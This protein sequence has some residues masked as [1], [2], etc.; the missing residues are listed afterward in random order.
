MYLADVKTLNQTHHVNR[1]KARFARLLRLTPQFQLLGPDCV[2]RADAEICIRNKFLEAY[3]AE[4]QAFLPQLLSMKC[5]GRLSGVA[6]ICQAGRQQLFLERYLS[7]PVEQ[8]LQEKLGTATHRNSIVEIG[9]LVATNNGASLAIFIVLATL[10]YQAGFSHMVFTATEKLRNKFEK[11]GFETA[12][13]ADADP[14]CLVG[15]DADCW[16]SYYANKPQ[17]VAGDLLMACK[18]IAGR[19]LFSCIELAFSAQI[20]SL[21]EQLKNHWIQ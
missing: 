18:L 5:G 20:H 2:Q 11:L 7:V 12:V 21:S 10:L 8:A 6:G 17:V 19:P 4:L 3:G 14:V 13:L 1:D 16:G 9:N 15:A